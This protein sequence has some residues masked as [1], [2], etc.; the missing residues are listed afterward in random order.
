MKN[1]KQHKFIYGGIR[2]AIQD[3][4]LPGSGAQP[5]YYFDYYFC[6]KCLEPKTIKLLLESNNYCDILFGATP[7]DE[8]I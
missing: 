1:C 2:Y 8:R 5:V 6:E 7:I 3:W 4:K